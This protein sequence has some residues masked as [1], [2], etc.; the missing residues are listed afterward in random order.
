MY[1]YACVC[2]CMVRMH[3]RVRAQGVHVCAWCVQGA[4]A[5]VCDIPPIRY[6]IICRRYRM[7]IIIKQ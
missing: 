7:F 3:A 1:T 6:G 2:V 4:R 5:C